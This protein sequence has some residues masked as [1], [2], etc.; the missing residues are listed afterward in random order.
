MDYLLKPIQQFISNYLTPK[1]TFVERLHDVIL[2]SLLIKLDEQFEMIKGQI[3]ESYY[4]FDEESTST[5]FIQNHQHKIVIMTNQLS[6]NLMQENSAATK[7][8]KTIQKVLIEKLSIL[9]NFLETEYAHCLDSS[10]N[11]T[12]AYGN[13]KAMESASFLANID[14]WINITRTQ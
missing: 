5:H 9:L 8:K 11:I 6:L 4:S 13:E 2:D 1:N 12:T 14:T 7:S 10:Y 3:S